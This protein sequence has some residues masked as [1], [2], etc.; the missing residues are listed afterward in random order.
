MKTLSPSRSSGLVTVGE[1]ARR[2]GVAPITIQRWV[3][4]G[5][6]RARRTAGG[7]RRIPVLE[8]RQRLAASR[9]GTDRQNLTAWLDVFYA[10]E[11]TEVAKLLH[12]ARAGA[13]AWARVADEVA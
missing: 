2:L 12:R 1:A 6:M 5:S 3:D 9:S 7:H 11:T 10:A 8:I 13:G 4:E